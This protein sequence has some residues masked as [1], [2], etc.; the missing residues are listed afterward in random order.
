MPFTH[1]RQIIVHWLGDS[2]W[3]AVGLAQIHHYVKPK[4][5]GLLTLIKLNRKKNMSAHAA[6]E[7][8]YDACEDIETEAKRWLRNKVRLASEPLDCSRMRIQRLRCVQ[9]EALVAGTMI[10]YGERRGE[11]LAAARPC[12]LDRDPAVSPR[13]QNRT[14]SRAS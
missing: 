3:S 4:G 11:A 2:Q 1:R 9:R 14:A 8:Y 5:E 7:D 12:R 6:G 10:L 13:A